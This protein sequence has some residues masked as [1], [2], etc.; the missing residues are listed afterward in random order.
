[1]IHLF[2]AI[3]QIAKKNPEGFTVRI[4]SLEW[5]LEGYIAAYSETQNC[6]GDEGLM[7]V[8]KHAGTHDKI[9]GGWLNKENKQ[10]YFDSDKQFFSKEKAIEFG[11]KHKQIAIFDLQTFREIRL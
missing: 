1:M 11:Q 3:K 4:P 6:F 9:V 10:F 8:L 7:K 5:V 2:E